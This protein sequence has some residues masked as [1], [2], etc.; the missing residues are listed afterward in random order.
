MWSKG[1]GEGQEN[2]ENAK[3][4]L[5]LVRW[6]QPLPGEWRREVL[7]GFSYKE[8][9]TPHFST[10]WLLNFITD[11]AGK[12]LFKWGSSAHPFIYSWAAD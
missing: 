10:W 12:L 5:K 11:K 6:A 3:T 8:N 7:L 2:L 4:S 1:G 9:T